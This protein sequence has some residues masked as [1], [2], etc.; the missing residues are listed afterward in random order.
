MPPL[1]SEHIATRSR[2]GCP[3]KSIAHC[4]I[5]PEGARTKLRCGGS[6]RL[7]QPLGQSCQRVLPRGLI[8]A[9]MR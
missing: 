5:I 8:G 1:Q 9:D 4:G 7:L 2:S 3:D 6:M